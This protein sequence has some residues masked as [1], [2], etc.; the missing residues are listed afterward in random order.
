[1]P[2]NGTDQG[3][4]S[5]SS[6]LPSVPQSQSRKEVRTVGQWYPMRR[7]H[8]RPDP[9]SGTCTVV[10]GDRLFWFA[11]LLADAEQCSNELWVYSFKNEEWSQPACEGM[12]GLAKER[13]VSP[14]QLRRAPARAQ[15][16]SRVPFNQVRG[17]VLCAMAAE[18]SDLSRRHAGAGQDCRQYV[19]FR[20]VGGRSQ[21]MCAPEEEWAD[22]QPLHMHA[23]M[24][25]YVG[26]QGYAVGTCRPP[27]RTIHAQEEGRLCPTMHKTGIVLLHGCIPCGFEHAAALLS[28]TLSIEREFAVRFYFMRRTLQL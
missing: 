26:E 20:C 13:I 10:I 2:F 6:A 15:R 3:T 14:S 9:V 21:Q 24:C 22:K 7:Q 23:S 28:P 16:S 17:Q 12:S 18:P 8:H 27:R 19:P 1:M 5:S 25:R 11:G 4:A